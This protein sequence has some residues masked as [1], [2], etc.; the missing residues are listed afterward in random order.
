MIREGDNVTKILIFLPLFIYSK[1][2]NLNTCAEAVEIAEVVVPDVPMINE[3]AE[4]DDTSTVDS[5][6]L[7]VN[8]NVTLVNR[9]EH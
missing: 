6:E 1:K 8:L 5:D 9:K 3:N 2:R 7:N 4:N